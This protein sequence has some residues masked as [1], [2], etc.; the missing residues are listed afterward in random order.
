MIFSS[1][2]ELIIYVLLELWCHL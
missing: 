2:Q 1:E